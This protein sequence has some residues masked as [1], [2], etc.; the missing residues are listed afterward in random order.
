V[1]FTSRWIDD[2]RKGELVTKH[3]WGTLFL[4]RRD[5][6]GDPEDAN[7][8]VVESFDRIRS[9]FDVAEDLCQLV[10][11]AERAERMHAVVLR[12]FGRDPHV[13]NQGDIAEFLELT[14]HLEKTVADS[15]LDG[16]WR[17]RPDQLANIRRRTTTLD[18]DESRGELAHAGVGEGLIDVLRLREIL[19]HARDVGLDVAMD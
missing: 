16:R 13:M 7:Q 18:L 4:V 10:G 3:R 15:L 6:V 17:V 11:D 5:W 2:P 8:S 19:K 9:A 14:E 12:A 1:A